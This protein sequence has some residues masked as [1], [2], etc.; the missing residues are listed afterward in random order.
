[1]IMFIQADKDTDEGKWHT[2]F[3][4]TGLTDCRVHILPDWQW[5]RLGQG[6]DDCI[7]P[8]RTEYC[9]ICWHFLFKKT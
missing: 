7:E 6:R 3:N 9:P 5:A 2:Y 1:M 8:P 4:K